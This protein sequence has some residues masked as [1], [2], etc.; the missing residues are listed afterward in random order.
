MNA[1]IIYDDFACAAK[2][3][4]MLEIQT[5]IWTVVDSIPHDLLDL[6]SSPF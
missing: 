3:K 1:V 4:V 5:V 6:L 2:A